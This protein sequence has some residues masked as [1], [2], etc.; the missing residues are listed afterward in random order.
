MTLLNSL[1]NE[2]VSM[3]GV[4]AVVIADRAGF[5]IEK[6]GLNI[7]DQVL[8]PMIATAIA[9]ADG[10]VGEIKRGNVGV[11][12]IETDI[13]FMAIST[14]TDYE[15]VAVVANSINLGKVLYKLKKMKPA[16]QETLL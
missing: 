4:I 1:M 16:F 13:G 3:D 14:L 15:N 2:F 8:G 6:S 9:V 7:S 10:F 5:I 11:I 12:V